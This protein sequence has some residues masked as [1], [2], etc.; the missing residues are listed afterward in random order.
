MFVELRIHVIDQKQGILS[1]RIEIDFHLSQVEGQQS[2]PLLSSGCV[3]LNRISVNLG[4]DLVAMGSDDA[5][6][7]TNLSL[8]MFP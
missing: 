8:P 7:E 4:C 3:A 5:S 1:V 2:A 6:S